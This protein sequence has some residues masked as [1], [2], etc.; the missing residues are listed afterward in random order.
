GSH[1]YAVVTAAGDWTVYM[2]DGTRITQT[3]SIQRIQD[4]N[5]NK[6][7]IFTDSAGTHYQDELTGRE[8][9]YF[10]D[11]T[12]NG[13]LGQGQVHYQAAGGNP[14]R[15]DINFGSTN[16]QGKLYRVNGWISGQVNPNPCV[17][18]Q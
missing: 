4:T 17:Y 8:I 7:K 3:G 1:L 9:R 10:F 14:M 2:P 12:A 6:I 16:V 5:G 18:Q 11:Q 15:I 13:G